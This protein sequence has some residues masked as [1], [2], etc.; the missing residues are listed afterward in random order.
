MEILKKFGKFLLAVL[1]VMLTILLALDIFIYSIR[2]MSSHYFKEETIKKML[3]TVDFADLLLDS[4][5]N[6]LE[7][8]TEIKK[9]LVEAGI[10]AEVI[11]EFLNAQPIKEVI[12]NVV[13][14]GVDYIVY[15]KEIETPKI[16]SDDVY[17]FFEKNM[18]IIVN[19]LQTNNVPNSELLTV[20]KQEMV[21]QQIKENAPIIEG[22]VNEVVDK[23]LEEIQKMDEY[24]QLENY[25]NKAYS[26]LDMIHYIYS[27]RITN[28]LL[29]GGVV[30]IVLIM[31]SR[32][33]FYK[34][35]KWIG[36]S[37][38]LSGSMIFLMKIFLP[39]IKNELG[40]VP[41]IFRNFIT[42][43]FEDINS[44]C[45]RNG[46]ICFIIAVIFIVMN[47]IGYIIH[48]KRDNKSFEI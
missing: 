35:F 46:S 41:S 34:G 28:I 48:E 15:D 32:W 42:Y 36:F 38:I 24:Q 20:E 33:S 17:K 1:T 11:Q 29:I 4:D 21:L 23:A 25:K 37:F 13:Q 7:Q 16:D 12:S 14:T 30:C 8:I 45:I 6:E 10:P 18:P 40:E 31:L 44:L 9:E 26:I 47:I 27:K 19:D 22:K 3:D 39:F 2:D 43:I 5:G